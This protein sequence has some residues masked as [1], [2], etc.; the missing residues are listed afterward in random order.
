M[1]HGNK[2]EKKTVHGREVYP[3]FTITLITRK[4]ISPL[5]MRRPSHV[6]G[7]SSVFLMPRIWRWLLLSSLNR[8]KE[9]RGQMLQKVC[10]TQD[11]KLPTTNKPK[12]FKMHFCTLGDRNMCVLQTPLVYGIKKWQRDA[13]NDKSFPICHFMSK[14]ASNILAAP[15]SKMVAVS[16]SSLGFR[17]ERKGFNHVE[18]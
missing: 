4:S 13:N 5:D 6:Y 16:E 8:T 11:E 18:I 14:H 1:E 10:W 15:N 7:P 12:L 9:A 3:P 17:R 2:G